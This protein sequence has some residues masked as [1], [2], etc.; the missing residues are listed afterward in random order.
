MLA[1]KNKEVPS[2]ITEQFHNASIRVPDQAAEYGS[3]RLQLFL[4]F[5]C[6][7]PQTCEIPILLASLAS[8]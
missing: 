8:L 5:V 2:L 3:S 4:S 7:H 1:V 6:S